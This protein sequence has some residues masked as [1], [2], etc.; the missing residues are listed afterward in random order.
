MNTQ[1]GPCRTHP[2]RRDV[3][4]LGIGALAVTALPL[5]RGRRRIVRRTI[6]V[7][8]TVG[9]I[10][11]LH[12]D[13]HYAHAAMDAA[14]NQ[15]RWVERTMTRFES[16]SDVGRANLFAST[17]PV[18]VT[19]ATAKVLQEAIAWAETTDGAFDPCFGKAIELWDVAN[20][21]EPPPIACVQRLAGRALYRKL[22]LDRWNGD[23]VVRFTNP[24]VAIDLGGIAKGY[25]VDRAVQILREWGVS[26]A[27][28]NVG[29]DLYGL[30]MSENDDPWKVGIRS[31]YDPGSL[32]ATVEV[33]EGA[34]ATSGDYLQYF[35]HHGTRYHHLLDP[36]TGA[37]RAGRL[38]SV[39][40]TA[41]NCM[42]ADAAA[43]AVFGM[44]VTAADRVLRTRAQGARVVHRV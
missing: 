21:H 28:V 30:G 23:Q 14:F 7:M 37:P 39:T 11:V 4:I 41:D 18:H 13:P 1:E 29:G 12:H 31:P 10:V 43:T 2:T 15:L 33:T 32:T 3:L 42:A 20:R 24:D 27:L 17:G 38:H 19:R 26:R 9:E 25:G 36:T 5:A 44:R 34:V 40:V 8:G 6:P 35:M 16:W 22:D